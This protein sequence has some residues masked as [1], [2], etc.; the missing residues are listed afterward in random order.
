VAILLCSLLGAARS[1][2]DSFG[3]AHLCRRHLLGTWGALRI[4]SRTK[5]FSDKQGREAV[6]FFVYV[7]YSERKG[8]HYVGQTKSVSERLKRHNGG[9]SRSTRN[10]RP[11]RVIYCEEFDDRSQAAR[12]ERYLKSPAGWKE[13]SAM[14]QSR[15]TTQ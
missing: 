13:Y 10:G 4:A 11:W 15:G 12:R 5:G 14:K 7:L 8:T 6:S 3:I 9:D 1:R 2:R